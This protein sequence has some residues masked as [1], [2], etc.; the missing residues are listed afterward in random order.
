[1]LI[2]AKDPTSQRPPPAKIS[3]FS[4]LSS[5]FLGSAPGLAD[6]MRREHRFL[7]M[8]SIHGLRR[9]LDKLLRATY[10]AQHFAGTAHS[11]ARLM[12]H[13]LALRLE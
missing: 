6:H 9:P 12:K 11:P 3:R 5:I 4:T 2:W 7:D 8:L 13:E 1:M 10:K